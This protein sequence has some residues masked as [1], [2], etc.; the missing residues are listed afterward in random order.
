MQVQFFGGSLHQRRL[1]IAG[2]LRDLPRA[3]DNPFGDRDETYVRQ[4]YHVRDREGAIFVLQ[5]YSLTPADLASV[6]VDSAALAA[7]HA[8]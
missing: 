5:G 8:A 2:E 4:P 3:L 6:G 1:T 7:T